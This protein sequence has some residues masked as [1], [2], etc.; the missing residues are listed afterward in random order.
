VP[1]LEWKKIEEAMENGSFNYADWLS[2]KYK[3]SNLDILWYEA[4]ENSGEDWALPKLDLSLS[5]DKIKL[6]HILPDIGVTD[7]Q[8]GDYYAELLQAHY[9]REEEAVANWLA[10]QDHFAMPIFLSYL[11]LPADEGAFIYRKSLKLAEQGIKSQLGRLGNQL[12]ERID[13]SLSEED[14][15]ALTA[16]IDRLTDRLGDSLANQLR[17]VANGGLHRI[18]TSAFGAF[19]SE[20]Y[21]PSIDPFKAETRF[22]IKPDVDL[23]MDYGELFRQLTKG[24]GGFKAVFE[25]L[26][27]GDFKAFDEIAKVR[28]SLGLAGKIPWTFNESSNA[29]IAFSL[30]GKPNFADLDASSFDTSFEFIW[31]A[32]DK[33]WSLLFS[34]SGDVDLNG[35]YN[36]QLNFELIPG[37]G[38]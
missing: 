3:P 22:S 31:A 16:G 27:K 28:P 10:R 13:P 4:I 9:C 25:P 8:A 6:D 15:L 2:G 12:Q 7:S 33:G 30:H 35:K 37:S 21:N 26:F 29:S 14:K 24:S 34:G 32:P 11:G 38:H 5:L 17:F 19:L 36:I 18:D 1:D 20:P 23:D